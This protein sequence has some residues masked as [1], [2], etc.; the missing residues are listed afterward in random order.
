MDTEEQQF[1]ELLRLNCVY[2]N[3]LKLSAGFLPHWY[4][5][6]PTTELAIHS[7]LSLVNPKDLL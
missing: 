5:Y 3:I 7:E 4:L 2:K 6:H 1:S